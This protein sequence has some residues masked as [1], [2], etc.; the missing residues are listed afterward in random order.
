M[1]GLLNFILCACINNFK[2][3]LWLY[4]LNLPFLLLRLNVA[5]LIYP[6]IIHPS[7]LYEIQCHYRRP[8]FTFYHA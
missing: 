6:K 7:F 5:K 4:R 1:V 3:L 2:V 8:P